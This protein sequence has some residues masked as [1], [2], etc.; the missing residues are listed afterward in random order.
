MY[1]LEKFESAV[2]SLATSAAD[3][4]QR[5]HNA[6]MSVFTVDTE[7]LPE[8]ARSV[9]ESLMAELTKHEAVADEGSVAASLKRMTDAE[10]EAAAKKIVE[11]HDVLREEEQDAIRRGEW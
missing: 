4:R 1:P 2:D 7:E 10:C 6:Y 3:I 11:I 8:R 5:L 9:H